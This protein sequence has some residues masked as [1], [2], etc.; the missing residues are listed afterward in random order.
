M[1]KVLLSLCAII[2]MT[3]LSAQ[4]E[5]SVSLSAGRK[6]ATGEPWLDNNG[7]MINAHGGGML[8]DGGIYYWFGEHKVEGKKGNSAW[9][10]VHC[11]SSEDLYNWKDEGIALKVSDDPAS[12]YFL[13]KRC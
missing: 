13:H 1:K 7:V 10:G 11:Y 4:N 5:P 6:F 12:L 3:G 8:F 9:V 2:I